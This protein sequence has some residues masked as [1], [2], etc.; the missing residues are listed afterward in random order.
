MSENDSGWTLADGLNL[1]LVIAYGVMIVVMIVAGVAQRV[2]IT[3]P[4]VGIFW[5]VFLIVT[6]VF[7]MIREPS[8]DTW[9]ELTREWSLK[10]TTALPWIFGVAAGRWFHPYSDGFK[11][12]SS[13]GLAY[14]LL[15][16]STAVVVA[17][18]VLLW[19]KEKMKFA[20]PWA[21]LILGIAAG[22]VFVPAQFPAV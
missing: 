17:L 19:K 22:L 3:I 7:L 8:G 20:P 2:D 4:V 12:I 10:H 5:A 6:D 11:L 16:V 13:D 18:G 14:T 9:S 1:A 15:G 21:V